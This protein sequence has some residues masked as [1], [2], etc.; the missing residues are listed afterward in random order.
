MSKR[1][2]PSAWDV[3]FPTEAVGSSAALNT[4]SQESAPATSASTAPPA[5]T[6]SVDSKRPR[7]G[8]QL[9]QRRGGPSRPKLSYVPSPQDIKES[10]NTLIF[11]EDPLERDESAADSK[12]IR[13]LSDFTVFDPSREF[14]MI[15]LA[16]LDTDQSGK[17]HFEAAGAVAPVFLNEEDEGQEDVLDG[18][19]DSDI[20]NLQRLRTSAIFR[21]TID[22]A[23]SDDPLYLETEFSW[24]ELRVP[25]TKYHTIHQDFYR[26][27]RIAQ[28]AISTAVT[29]P[30]MSMSD[31]STT[32]IGAWDQLTGEVLHDQDFRDAIPLLWNIVNGYEEGQRQSLLSCPFLHELLSQRPSQAPSST[33]QLVRRAPP[34]ALIDLASLSGNL[35]LVVLRPEKQNPTHVSPLIDSL[36]LGLFHEHLKVVGPRQRRPG[37]AALKRQQNLM[38]IALFDLI[39]RAGEPEHKVSVKFPADRRLFDQY[40]AAVVVD[41]E[42]YEVGDCI[43]VEAQKYGPRAKPKLPDN[44]LDLP[45]HVHVADFCWFAKIIYID[46]LKSELHVQWYEHGS[47]TF[48]QEI[49][50][51][52][53]LYLWPTCSPICVKNVLGKARVTAAPVENPG[54]LDFF[55]RFTYNEGDASFVDINEKANSTASALDPPSNCACCL[56]QAQQDDEMICTTVHNGIAFGGYK[57]H[58]DEYVLYREHEGPAGLGRITRIHTAKTTRQSGTATVEVQRLGR[59][60]TYFAALHPD[61]SRKRLIH[62]REVYFTDDTIKLDAR[63]LIKPC[64]VVQ[65]T[66]VDDLEVWLDLSPCHFF[67]RCHLPSLDSPWGQR[68]PLKR[69]DVP[70]CASCLGQDNLRCEQ[71][72]AFTSDRQ[73]LLRTFDPFGGVGAFGLAM[74]E[75]GCLK[76]THAVEIT[77]SAALTLKKNSPDTIVYN[78]CSNLVYKYAVKTHMKNLNPAEDSFCNLLDGTPLPTPPGPGDID[79]LV[80]GFPCQPHSHL[81]MFRKANDR[82]SHLMLNLLSWVDFLKPKY[83]FFENVRGFLSYNLHAR[84][85]GR[86]R[87]E[88]GIKMGGLK[89]FVRC[90]LAMGY[91]VRFSLLQAGHYGTPQSRAR[92]FLIAALQGHQLPQLPQPSHDFPLKDGLE[93][94]FP[95]QTAIQPILTLNGTA[96]CKFISVAEAI[97]DLPEFDWLNPQKILQS[98]ALPT[99]R[100][101][102]RPAFKCD[103]T[104]TFCGFKGPSEVVGYRYTKPHTSFQEKCRRKPTSDLQHYTRTLPTPT[105]ERVVNV[106]L[107]PGAD[108]RQLNP[109]LWQWHTT[110]PNSAVARDGFRPG[111]Y[112]RLDATQWFHTTVTNVD[113]SAKQSYVLHPWCRRILTVRELARSQGFPDWFV[114]YSIDNNVKTLQRHIGNAVPWPVS[115]ALA[116]ELRYARLQKWLQDREDAI[117]VDSD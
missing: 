73:N 44:P 18:V 2:R 81:N 11:G 20:S 105:V 88:G 56:L 51:P 97:G 33:T 69:Q 47:K 54:P 98:Q 66:D 43:I 86:Y 9:E 68:R 42:T 31:F 99:S 32:Y 24:Y 10:A 101:N 58:R 19:D 49:C 84:Q 71:L 46:Q 114:F 61:A 85:A 63:L 16:L 45:E 83:C 72:I 27:H 76:L 29:E 50:D 26:P 12:P 52:N 21:Y 53:E 94:K 39:H 59:V 34:P 111:L 1:N 117:P 115:E 36:A 102:A 70:A 103:I 60:S 113:P 82:K 104:E 65:H 8:S 30:S 87:V 64:F 37:K 109:H 38:T 95:N 28:V 96:P 74:E 100:E 93:I 40:W 41:G 22:Y 55:C 91:Q 7:I 78:Q 25:S 3:S 14:E 17:H 112:G 35:D 62:E 90:L 79:C 108:Y 5:S 107:L 89:F 6:R 110:N 57:Y 80:A 4:S 67:A 13:A 106:P 15:S 48:L 116:R 92:F 75:T 23:K 77:P